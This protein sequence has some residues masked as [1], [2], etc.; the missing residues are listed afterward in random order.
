LIASLRFAGQ[1]HPA[2][3][4][5]CALA[6]ALI[7]VY[8]YLR[9][10]KSIAAPYS[11]LLPALRATAVVMVILI[12]AGPTWHRRQTIGTLGRII[13]AV[14]ASHSMAVTDSE[15][16]A[17][18]HTR[19]QQA[20][21]LLLG[22]DSENGWLADLSDSHWIEVV[23]LSD[24]QAMTLWTNREES[25][26]P[27]G[28]DLSADGRV[29]NLTAAL[30]TPTQF[31]PETKADL[32][33]VVLIS[34]GNHNH[35]PSPVD[36]AKQLDA[37]GATVHTVGTGSP[38][39]KPDLGIRR[40]D[41]P[42][43]VAI[44]ALLR[45]KIIV[46]QQGLTGSELTA[47]IVH[48]RQAVWQSQVTATPGIN[49]IPFEFAIQP[50]IDRASKNSTLDL[51]RNLV[52]ISLTAVI[53]ELPREEFSENNRHEF[54]ITATANQIKL[55]IVDGSSRWETRYINN[56]FQRDPRYDVQLRLFGPGTDAPTIQRGDQPGQLPDS[57]AEL[58]RY[59][60][61]ILGEVPPE[62]WTPQD[63]TRLQ[64]FVD[65][66]GGLIIVD[67]HFDRIQELADDA[68]RELLPVE[69]LQ[70]PALPVESIR[71]TATGVDHPAL[72]LWHDSTELTEFWR[73]LPGPPTAPPVAADVSAEVLAELITAN[74]L[75]RPWLVTRKYGAGRIFYLSTD[76]TWR[77]RY[78][79]ADRFHAKF[80]NRLLASAMHPP[81]SI[82]NRFAALATDRVDY[83][84]GDS[85]TIRAR[86]RGIDGRPRSDAT[87]EGILFRDGQTVAT[88]PL[89]IDDPA[90]GTFRGQTPPLEPGEYSVGV[91]AS[92]VDAKALD[93]RTP[94]WVVYD[95]SNELANLSLN[96]GMLENIASQAGGVYV[97]ESDAE[98]LLEE[99]QPRSEG[100][101]VTSDTVLWQSYYWFTLVVLILTVE[102][103]LRKR[104]GLT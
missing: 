98:R 38:I 72:Q 103:L 39:A 97:H 71:P 65:R 58:A 95:D 11:Y 20:I 85:A 73:A 8:F 3:V 76:Q 13:F 99:I 96:D 92:G 79:T 59:D 30:P 67:G 91:R 9:E 21:T 48:D 15:W 49:A 43:T 62:Q 5:G 50:L 37:I 31:G 35:G 27:L 22:S 7:V 41:A 46:H 104:V 74:G 4:L 6:A 54:R 57:G 19:L 32:L 44:D 93:I 16:S 51:Q 10:T 70:G 18:D 2:L 89:S 23:A 60:A 101:I 63:S 64:Q 82:E 28:F 66:G 68:F 87:V 100:R 77:W 42:A 45:G 81:F 36:R 33:S 75:S 55:L 78:K 1:L 24:G 94:I 69:H 53:D 88:I 12:L 25:Q 26:I 83:R 29:T 52:A 90:R 61:I 56:L 17:A 84:V 102:W 34:D 14:D 40:I 47:R 86:V 80:W